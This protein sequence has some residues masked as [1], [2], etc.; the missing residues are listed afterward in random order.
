MESEPSASSAWILP[1]GRML[2]IA[3]L[4][5]LMA[6]AI[7]GASARALKLSPALIAS[8]AALGALVALFSLAELHFRRLSL[9][10]LRIAWLVFLLGVVVSPVF[11]LQIAYAEGLWAGGVPAG[12]NA[13][14]E[15]LRF[16]WREEALLTL[17]ISAVFGFACGLNSADPYLSCREAGLLFVGQ[18]AILTGAAFLGRSKGFLVLGA[19]VVLN[20]FVGGAFVAISSAADWID[21][22]FWPTEDVEDALNAGEDEEGA[23]DHDG[24]VPV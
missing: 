17:A 7:L 15:F 20:V 8:F 6:A 10:P 4:R 3:G 23:N 1:T 13:I 9:S 18:A 14:V 19:L 16:G 11:L 22:S 5:G 2:R 21:R 12:L 24:E